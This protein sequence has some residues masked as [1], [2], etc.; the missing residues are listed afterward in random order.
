MSSLEL[1]SS[2]MELSLQMQLEPYEKSRAFEGVI[3]HHCELNISENVLH[4]L[5]HTVYTHIS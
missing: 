5:E 1:L 2:L 3:L 4:K